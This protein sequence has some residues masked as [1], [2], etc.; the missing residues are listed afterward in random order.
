MV[1]LSAWSVAFLS[2][3]RYTVRRDIV[4]FWT[5]LGFAALA[6]CQMFYVLT[7]P[8]LLPEGRAIVGNLPSTA[9]WIAMLALGLPGISLLAAV[10]V[11]W[12]GPDALEG[13]RWVW[14]VGG[15]LACLVLVNVGVVIFEESLPALVEARGQF[16]PLLKMLQ[17]FLTLTFG[18][19][20][21]ASARYYIRTGDTLPGYTALAQLFLFFFELAIVVGG[22]RYSQLFFADRFL[23]IG[24]FLAMLFGLLLDYVKLHGKELERT[25][26]LER[27]AEQLRKSEERYREFFTDDL[28]GDVIS[29]PEGI[30]LLCNPAFARMFGFSAVEEAVGTNVV[31]LYLDGAERK[32]LVQRVRRER[33]IERFEVW[34]KRRDGT[35]IHIVENL[36][37]HFDGR[38]E[39]FE[40]KGYLFDDTERKRAEGA[41]RES[42]KR[43]ATLVEQAPVG[44]F[45][46]DAQGECIFVNDGWQALAGLTAAESAGKG[47]IRAIHPEDRERVV[48][49]WYAAA[50]GQ[51]EFSS[52]YRFRTPNGKIS[53]VMARAKPIQ[54]GGGGVVRHLGTL[55]DITERKRAEQLEVLEN[56]F[57][58]A[59]SFLHVLRGPKLIFEFANEAYYRLVGRRDLIG[60]PAFEAMPEAAEGGYP[61]RI[62]RVMETG[63]AFF[64]RELPVTLERTPGAKTEERIIDLVYVPLKE[65]D[66]TCTGVLGH[67]TD[68]TEHVRERRQAEEAVRQKAE[69]LGAV[70]DAAPVAVWVAQDRECRVITGN[71]YADELI[72][73]TARGGNIS[74][75][76]APGEAA[77]SYRVFRDGVELE[78]H[79]LPAQ[80]ATATGK[81][82][83]A[84]EMELVFPNGRRLNLM[85]GAVPLFSHEGNVRGAI[86]AGLDV[87]ALR[88]AQEQLVRAEER[89][90]LALQAGRM[91]TWDRIMPDGPTVWNEDHYRILGYDSTQ[92]TASKEAWEARVHPEDL[93]AFY[94]RIRGVLK[95]GGDFDEELRI[96]WP[97]GEVRWVELR[98]SI[99]CD[100]N[101]EARR[102]YGV[103]LDFTERK[104]AEEELRIN[105]E[106]LHQA[107]SVAGL[108][109]FH[110]DHLSGVV[111]YSPVLRELMGFDLEAK[112]TVP[113]I[114]EKVV[115]EDREAMVEAVC[116]AH[117]PAGDGTFAVDHRVRHADGR[118]RWISVRSQTFFEGEGNTRRPV[119]TIGAGLDVTERKEAQTELERLVAERTSKLKELVG[120]LEH[121]SYTITHDLKSPL[122]A[123]RGFA[124][125]AGEICGEGEY[126][127][128]KEFLGRISTAAERMDNLIADALSYSRAVRQELPL[129]DVDSGALLRGMLDSYPELQSEKAR[130]RVEGRLP[131]VLANQAG[132][133]QCFSNLLGN[134]VKFVKPGQLPEIRVWAEQRDGRA[135]IWVEDN[136][137]GIAKEMLPR[138]FE[139][140]TRGSKDYEGTGI[141]LALVRK[142][143][144]RMGGLVGVE[145]EEGKGSRFWIELK[146]GERHSGQ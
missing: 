80:R 62:A 50:Q 105:R 89:A 13:R 35:Q 70:L 144:Q 81:P 86:V 51:R 31:D 24:G 67:G 79:E 108:G 125:L 11:R 141:G 6:T 119:R 87:T 142:V 56:V 137:I 136:G 58:L 61:E 96:V 77:V 131:M 112:V 10:W 37:G 140:F 34:R 32:R 46:T 17:W 74:R 129:E 133:T 134:A 95:Q 33:K 16:T 135:R 113:A 43:F 128:T 68:V 115:P 60:R 69:E 85:A 65:A 114:L 14:L 83:P 138:M 52:E 4:S 18:L 36:V 9:A 139:M 76:A 53:W 71:A 120:E 98:G 49:D 82:V 27:S 118:V 73:G 104:R 54:D 39:L 88:K 143:A 15:C 102:S 28:T 121:F 101:G 26:E 63:E 3:G 90:R 92:M 29:T 22:T 100:S 84:F 8:G 12:P 2:F 116:R 30:I 47:W 64:G 57:R 72:M 106:R 109:T 25:S 45:E 40:I 111:D 41:L 66:G 1:M 91:G 127:R 117:D 44:I 48:A 145:S 59:P 99:E 75:S 94:E 123:M 122:R 110:H 21:V 132:L 38:G 124:E 126:E 42:E 78:S 93:R 107:I 146:C 20:A 97:S 23:V 55:L 103:V 130:I 5:G 7:W 19:G